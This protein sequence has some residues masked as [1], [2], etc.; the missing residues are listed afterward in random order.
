MLSGA[1][2]EWLPRWESVV[3]AVYAADGYRFGIEE[4]SDDGGLR[5]ASALQTLRGPEG[6]NG[7]VVHAGAKHRL[8]TQRSGSAWPPWAVSSPALNR[9]PGR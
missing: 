8:G 2:T 3:Q 1:A 9:I 5:G 6:V 4:G 7:A